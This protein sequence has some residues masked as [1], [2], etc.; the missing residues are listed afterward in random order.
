ML[1]SDRDFLKESG[2]V[3][4]MMTCG[5]EFQ[6]LLMVLLNVNDFIA[7]FSSSS[8]SSSLILSNSLQ[9]NL[10]TLLFGNLKLDLNS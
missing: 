10:D 3:W 4:S 5:S 2:E 9:A 1:K 7:L 8:S 6:S